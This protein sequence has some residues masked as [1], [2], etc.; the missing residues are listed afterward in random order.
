MELTCEVQNTELGPCE[1]LSWDKIAVE[2]VREDVTSSKAHN[3]HEQI[4]NLSKSVVENYQSTH[5]RAQTLDSVNDQIA[6]KCRK[7]V[8]EMVTKHDLQSVLEAIVL[9]FSVWG[10]EM[11]TE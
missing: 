9:F 6:D 5:D 10:N 2:M 8:L 1:V 11:A 4:H 3:Q 7:P